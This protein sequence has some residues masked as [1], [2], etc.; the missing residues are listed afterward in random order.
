M[1]KKRYKGK[2]DSLS[3]D[4]YKV[5]KKYKYDIYHIKE[6][7]T[8]RNLKGIRGFLAKGKC[9]KSVKNY[10]IYF[11]KEMEIENK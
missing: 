2:L 10:I 5:G 6:G 1:G 11:F 7:S 3:I 9:A 8:I 4:I